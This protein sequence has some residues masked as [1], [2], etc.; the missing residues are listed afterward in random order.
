ML[1]YCKSAA[2]DFTCVSNVYHYTVV[3]QSTSGRFRRTLVYMQHITYDSIQHTRKY[4]VFFVT[5]ETLDASTSNFVKSDEL[6]T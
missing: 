3:K 4:P 1:F 2:D 6:T 5:M